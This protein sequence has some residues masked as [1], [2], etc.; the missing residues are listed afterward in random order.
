M[1]RT[2][3]I[4]SP[5][6]AHPTRFPP[7]PPS[8]D[9]HKPHDIASDSPHTPIPPH[10]HPVQNFGRASSLAR[11]L[12]GASSLA[13]PRSYPS[14]PA[15]IS[16]ELSLLSVLADSAPHPPIQPLCLTLQVVELFAERHDIWK[17]HFLLEVFSIQPQF[18]RMRIEVGRVPKLIPVEQLQ[19]PRSD[20]CLLP[21]ND[22]TRKP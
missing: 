16:S 18:P 20:L 11:T 15:R 10:R 22:R 17:Q 14:P 19:L 3:D 5:L 6:P 13:P 7:P 1:S 4:H 8:P 21:D 2:P 12:V 9:R